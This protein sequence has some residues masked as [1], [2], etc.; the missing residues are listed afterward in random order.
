MPEQKQE[1]GDNA[2]PIPLEALREIRASQSQI[3]D[4]QNQLNA[5]VTGVRIGMGLKGLYEANII[6]GEFVRVVK[7]VQTEQK[8][9]NSK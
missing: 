7:E 2:V 6:K 8:V 5:Y 1:T 4:I 9:S 3:T